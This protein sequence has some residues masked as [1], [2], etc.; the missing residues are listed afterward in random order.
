MLLGACLEH[1]FIGI[2]LI[3]PPPILLTFIIIMGG[4]YMDGVYKV[5]LKFI[6]S[7]V[8]G[9]KVVGRKKFLDP[10]YFFGASD[11]F[12]FPNFLPFY[13]STFLPL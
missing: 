7:Q 8:E 13:L 6:F 11:N 2:M 3:I 12:W 9:R 5:S 4:L 10:F 1:V